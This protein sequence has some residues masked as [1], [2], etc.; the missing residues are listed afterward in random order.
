M[1]DLAHNHILDTGIEGLKTTANAFQEI[2]LEPIG[3]NVNDQGIFVKRSQWHQS[4]DAGL[5]LRIQWQ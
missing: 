5:C 1:I 4:S 3:V 2:G